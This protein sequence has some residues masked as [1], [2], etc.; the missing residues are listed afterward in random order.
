MGHH[1]KK[2]LIEFNLSI[3][4]TNNQL[5]SDQEFSLKYEEKK[6]ASKINKETN[7]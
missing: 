4:G 6:S 2:Y 3:K 1:W 5:M 7:V